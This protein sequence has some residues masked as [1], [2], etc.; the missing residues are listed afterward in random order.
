MA[1]H[2]CV[3][4]RSTGILGW[5]Q[6]FDELGRMAEQAG[7]GDRA[8]SVGRLEPSAPPVEAFILF[9]ESELA[10]PSIVDQLSSRGI[11]TYFWRRDNIKADDP[12]AQIESERLSS[13]KAVVVFLGSQGWGA[14]Q[15]GLLHEAQSAKKPIVPVLIGDPP[16][17][18]L[19]EAGGIFVTLRY[20][21]LRVPSP[22]AFNL[23]VEALRPKAPA[24]RFD[25]LIGLLVDGDEEDR[26]AVL[27]QVIDGT[28]N[29]KPGL[30]ARLR[31][32][33]QTRFSPE[34]ASSFA[35]SARD[36]NRMPSI[37]SW[38]LSV[39]IWA[40]AESPLSRE[41]ILK[42]LNA[43]FEP[44]RNVRFWALA[45]LYQCRTSYLESGGQSCLSD[46]MPEVA[47]L[48]Q[49]LLVHAVEDPV[50]S[51]IVDRFRKMLFSDD[52]EHDAW[53]ALRVLRILPILPLAGDLC[54]LVDRSAGDT[55]LAYDA[56]YALADPAMAAEAAPILQQTRG[57]DRV[58]DIIV[59]VMRH[60]DLG[61]TR[62]FANL[63]AAFDAASIETA[64]TRA[65]ARDTRTATAVGVLRQRLQEL[66]RRPPD[67]PQ[68]FVAGYA[69]DAIDVTRDDLGIREDVQ[70]LTAV[71]LAREVVPP[72]AIGLFGDWGGLEKALHGLDQG[73]GEPDFRRSAE[74]EQQQIL[75][76][77]G[78]DRIQCL[79]LCRHQSLGE[80][81]S[82]TFWRAWPGM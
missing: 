31:D 28:I 66:R 9:N 63:L 49:A 26:S 39:L 32:E 81:P 57:I 56:L 44:A 21:D 25:D 13:A 4:T 19:K 45:G 24:G 46:P 2:H 68:S 79:A 50:K 70:T 59:E 78:F 34:N 35:S 73:Y 42:H 10:V 61:A 54:D 71:M 40:D 77:G 65:E 6:P 53:P 7:N 82:A 17:A 38:M 33:L 1:I 67:G 36:P 52:F 47:L 64:L 51:G 37:R 69:S 74:E 41:L 75:H 76:R 60:S 8:P 20:V 27:D 14:N 22:A 29:D 80:S 15:L 55:P 3:G 23:L 43:G 12:W 16:G 11:S 5:Q 30:G 62:H 48:A 58:L 72:L 18:A